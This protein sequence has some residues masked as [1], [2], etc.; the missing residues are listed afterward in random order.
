[1]SIN[2]EFFTNLALAVQIDLIVNVFVNIRS[3]WVKPFP[4]FYNSM[5][6]MAIALIYVRLMY[7]LGWNSVKLEIYKKR[8][9]DYDCHQAD[10]NL[11]R[12]G[13]LKEDL[14]TSSKETISGIISQYQMIRDFFICFFTIFF[15]DYPF[16]QIIP[17]IL[18]FATSLYIS[19]KYKPFE[20][21][22]MNFLTIVN[23]TAYLIVLIVF[24]VLYAN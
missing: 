8:F 9:G 10:S 13:F 16:F 12:W 5:L 14:K 15:M 11:S 6:S 22:F 4:L 7:I 3:F 17:N 23:E 18:L 2:L 24:L 1:M 21:K 19:V 20:S